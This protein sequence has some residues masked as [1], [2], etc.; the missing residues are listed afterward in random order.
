MCPTKGSLS[1]RGKLYLTH[2]FLIALMQFY[3]HWNLIS[4]EIFSFYR[5]QAFHRFEK[6]KG[7]YLILAKNSMPK[8]GSRKK[9]F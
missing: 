7:L 8:N 3:E 5:S 4:V 9:Y 1:V 6:K 2:T